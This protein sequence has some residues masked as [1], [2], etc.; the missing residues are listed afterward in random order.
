MTPVLTH[1]ALAVRDLERTIAF[2]RKH[3]HLHVVHQR[4]DAGRHV[5][6]LADRAEDAEVVLVLL[7]TPDGVDR[8]PRTLQH[9]GF[10]VGSRDEVDQAAAKA[11]EDGVLLM[12]PIEAGPIVGYFCLIE[13]PDGNPVEF[14]FGQPI[15]PRQLPTGRPPGDRPLPP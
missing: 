3:V 14:S 2:Y 1:V 15:N 4:V 8:G 9:L 6:W 11:R 12:E 7:E 5:A 10:G 13:D